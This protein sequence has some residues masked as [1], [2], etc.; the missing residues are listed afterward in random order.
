MRGYLRESFSITTETKPASIQSVHPMCTSPDRR[1]V[2]ELYI[3]GALLQ[4]VKDSDAAIEQRSTIDRELDPMGISIEE[5]HIE[6]ALQIGDG[7]RD[8][9][10]RRCEM[11]G[12][13]CHAALS[14][15]G[16]QD[17]EVAQLDAAAD[18]VSKFHAP[19]RELR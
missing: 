18:S 8:H 13:L 15:Q 7:L 1:I 14:R 17:I 9:R 19:H 12:R 10:L 3:E 4:F 11:P 5:P 2:K 6:Y 16:N